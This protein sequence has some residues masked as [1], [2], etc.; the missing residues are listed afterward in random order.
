MRTAGISMKVTFRL[1]DDL[2]HRIGLFLLPFTW[3]NL[4]D[5]IVFLV[6]F[7]LVSFVAVL[8]SLMSEDHILNN[9]DSN[10]LFL[11]G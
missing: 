6:Y 4:F 1:T 9:K 10:L 7:G 3:R 11:R 5:L 8:M 2:G